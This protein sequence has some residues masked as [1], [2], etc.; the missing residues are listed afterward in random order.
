MKNEKIVQAWDRL[1]PCEN[2]ADNIRKKIEKRIYVRMRTNRLIVKG[3]VLS[4]VAA[5][6]W[7][8]VCFQAPTNEFLFHVYALEQTE[9]NELIIKEIGINEQ[10]TVWGG[11]YDGENYYLNLGF[12]CGGENIEYVRLS[13]T[14][15]FF[16][17][18]T[19]SE[20]GSVF[21]RPALF[22]GSENRL[23]LQGTEFD[24]LDDSVVLKREE[25][26]MDDYLIFLGISDFRAFQ[27][28]EKIEVTA[29]VFYQDGTSRTY[30]ISFDF[31]NNIAFIFQYVRKTIS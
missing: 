17:K 10:T 9:S 21:S 25:L 15:S 20:D 30:P 4:C 29:D 11:Y 8:F 28:T 27:C 19:L 13:T 14:A 18:Q 1:N 26:L 31:S 16:A 12:R 6:L 22:L 23:A 24:V 2:S 3:V 5:F 7:L